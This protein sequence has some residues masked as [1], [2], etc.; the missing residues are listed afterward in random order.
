MDANEALS[1]RKYDQITV[2]RSGRKVARRAFVLRTGRI[3]PFVV[4]DYALRR[5][6]DDTMSARTHLAV[7]GQDSITKGW[8]R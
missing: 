1:L 2:R 4:V 3:G 5:H 8:T 7:A 6:D